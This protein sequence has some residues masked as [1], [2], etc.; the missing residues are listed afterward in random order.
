MGALRT[1]ATDL[2]P[3][4]T[5]YPGSLL[6]LKGARHSKQAYTEGKKRHSDP[7]TRPIHLHEMVLRHVSYSTGI[8]DSRLGI[9]NVR[10]GSKADICS[11]KGHVRFTPESGHVQCTSLCLLWANSGHMRCKREKT[12]SRRSSQP[13]KLC[14]PLAKSSLCICRSCPRNGL[15]CKPRYGHLPAQCSRNSF[16]R[17]LCKPS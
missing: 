11:A 2:Q 10:F 4:D 14:L 7:H 3:P 13:I 8:L 5:R 17:P 1:G 15:S 12:A 9:S 16:R 6:R